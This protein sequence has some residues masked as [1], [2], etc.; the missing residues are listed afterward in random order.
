VEAN[1]DGI[2][3]LN[4]QVAG[5]AVAPAHDAGR[6]AGP[7]D[8]IPQHH[9]SARTALDLLIVSA[10][11]IGQRVGAAKLAFRPIDHTAA[12]AEIDAIAVRHRGRWR[13]DNGPQ[14]RQGVTAHR[15]AIEHGAAADQFNDDR[16]LII[17]GRLLARETDSLESDAREFGARQIGIANRDRLAALII[18]GADMNAQPDRSVAAIWVDVCSHGAI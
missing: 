7:D 4:H 14:G 12:D 17:A 18:G 5:L 11:C 13:I 3:T 8:A 9:K 10:P 2:V 15:K 6:I 16:G 1:W